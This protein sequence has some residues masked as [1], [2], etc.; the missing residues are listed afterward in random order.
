M[1]RESHVYDRLRVKVHV[2]YENLQALVNRLQKFHQASD[3]L[4]RT[5]R[6]VIIAR[7]LQVQMNEIQGI[8]NPN[9]GDQDELATA[10]LM[11][12]KDIEDEKERAIAKAALSIA[13]LGGSYYCY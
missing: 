11:H 7:R 12:G 2:P 5:S 13:E 10:T 8:K 9:G 6:F 4:R 3:L 1:W